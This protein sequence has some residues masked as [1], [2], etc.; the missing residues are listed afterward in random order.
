MR[1]AQ[2]PTVIYLPSLGGHAGSRI[3]PELVTRKRFPFRRYS[4][5]E[6]G[7]M[8]VRVRHPNQDAR[9]RPYAKPVVRFNTPSSR[10][11]SLLPNFE[12]AS[13]HPTSTST[14]DPNPTVELLKSL[15]PALV[16]DPSSFEESI[17]SI[18][19]AHDIDESAIFAVMQATRRRSSIRPLERT[20]TLDQ[21]TPSI[22]VPSSTPTIAA[23]SLVPFRHERPFTSGHRGVTIWYTTQSYSDISGPPSGIPGVA[24]NL[25]VHK[26]L[27]TSTQQIW[28]FGREAQWT[29]V[30]DDMR[31]THPSVGD[32]MLSVRSDGSPNWVTAAGFT[33][34][35]ARKARIS[36]VR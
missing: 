27:S 2:P 6:D 4:I 30:P 5:Q 10:H 24:G 17:S 35:K 31:V 28:L 13:A 7:S 18:C 32:W 9:P 22:V 26:N 20:R 25:Y 36:D 1:N 16:E 34:L 14:S 11:A 15:V 21:S 12:S 23:V 19:A 29:V 3:T 33:N 8:V